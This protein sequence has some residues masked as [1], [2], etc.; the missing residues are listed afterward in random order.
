MVVLVLMVLLVLVVV[1]GAFTGYDCV[2]RS[3]G[4]VRG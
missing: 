4:V 3:G 2:R 1:V